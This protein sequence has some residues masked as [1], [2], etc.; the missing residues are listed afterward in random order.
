MLCYAMACYVMF[1]NVM[2]CY[3]TLY[4]AM[5]YSAMLRSPTPCFTTAP[6]MLHNV[7]LRYAMLCRVTYVLQRY[8][9]S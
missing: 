8:G 1:C 2:V 9:M 4:H 6:F 3:V 5:L 7:T